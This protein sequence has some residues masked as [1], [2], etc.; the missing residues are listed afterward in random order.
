MCTVLTMIALRTPLLR[1]AFGEG[2]PPRRW[3]RRLAAED[4]R[5]DGAPG[6]GSTG[7]GPSDLRTHGC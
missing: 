2:R 7:V 4:S 3:M 6:T 1:A 5:A